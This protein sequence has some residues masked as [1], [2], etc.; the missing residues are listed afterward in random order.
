MQLAKAK[1][2]TAKTIKSLDD[3]SGAGDADVARIADSILRPAW[4]PSAEGEMRAASLDKQ[5]DDVLGRSELDGQLASAQG[6]PGAGCESLV[7]KGGIIW[8][9]FSTKSKP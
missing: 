5:M 7:D 2:I 8:H 1:E 6:A 4:I 3:L 9:P